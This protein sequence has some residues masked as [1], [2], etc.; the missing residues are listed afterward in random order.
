LCASVDDDREGEGEALF[1]DD[2]A[3][4]AEVLRDMMGDSWTKENIWTGQV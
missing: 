1:Q 2:S 4:Y 3:E